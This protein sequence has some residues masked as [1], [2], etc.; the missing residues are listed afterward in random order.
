MRQLVVGFVIALAVSAAGAI[1]SRTRAGREAGERTLRATWF[2][3]AATIYFLV[4]FTIVV[5]AGRNETRSEQLPWLYGLLI[6]L[7]LGSSGW[8]WY[9]Y[10]RVVF[11]T[12]EGV[13]IRRPFMTTRFIQWEDVEWAGRKWSGDFQFRSGTT[14][15]SYTSYEGGHDELN[16]LAQRR[17][18]K[19]AKNF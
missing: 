9:F 16:R 12:A 4:L 13:G 2:T 15:I 8:I 5:I 19:F 11:W 6:G 14:R 18:P 1:G 7:G 3:H 17:F 10:A